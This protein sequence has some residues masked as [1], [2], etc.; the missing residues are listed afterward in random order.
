ME[1]EPGVQTRLMRT[2]TSRP[3]ASSSSALRKRSSDAASST[4]KPDNSSPETAY[5]LMKSE[6]ENRKTTLNCHK[7]GRK[8]KYKIHGSERSRGLLRIIC[9]EVTCKASISG[10]K[11]ID[12]LNNNGSKLPQDLGNQTKSTATSNLKKRTCLLYTSD[13]ADD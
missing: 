5:E 3:V 11:V 6:F 13:A 2:N 7:C 8:G 9:T 4:S 12:L 1:S 10:T